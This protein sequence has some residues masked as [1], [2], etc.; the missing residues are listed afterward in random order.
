MQSDSKAHELSLL[1]L[2]QRE[3][4]SALGLGQCDVAPGPW[5]PGFG[6]CGWE[7]ACCWY[8][9]RHAAVQGCLGHTAEA[10]GFWAGC[11]RCPSILGPPS[12]CRPAASWDGPGGWRPGY[13]LW[14]RGGRSQGPAVPQSS[15]QATVL[16]GIPPP[17]HPTL[18]PET[19]QDQEER[20]DYSSPISSWG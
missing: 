9:F 18:P 2:S 7:A 12:P 3:H 8:R 11:G 1:K 10:A 4:A 16:V 14:G 15:P 19:L 5:N 17:L 20:T 6:Q 13:S